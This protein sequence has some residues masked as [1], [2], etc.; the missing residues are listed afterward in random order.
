MTDREQGKRLIFLVTEL[1]YFCSHRLSLA[2]KAK[3]A[4]YTV[5][6]ITN[7]QQRASLARY[8]PSLAEL[9]ICHVPFN[10]SS[11]NPL[12]EVKV[13]GQILQLYRQIRPCI[14]HHVAIKGVLYGTL[15]ARLIKTPLII[16]ALGGLGHL[17]TNKSFKTLIIKRILI[18]GFRLVAN[19]KN[20]RWILQNP[21]DV[22]QM[23][24]YINYG[25]IHL[26]RG[27]GV[28]L[29]AFTPRKE[30]DYPPIIV[31][32]V[33]R[34]LWSKGLGE[35][36]EASKILK[37]Q[38]IA[39]E[40]QVAGEPDAHNPE[41]VPVETLNRWKKDKD[42]VWLG[43]REDIATL[44]GKSHMVILPSYREGLPRSLLEAL[45]CGKPVITT[46]APGCR[47]IVQSGVNGILIPPRNA[48]ALAQAMKQLAESADMRLKMGRASRLKAEQEFDEELI[49]AQTLNL[50]REEI[51]L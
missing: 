5:F 18:I 13:I 33:A 24:V 3:Q 42:V 39:V 47:E 34:L 51:V 40:I 48:T 27:A 43:Q 22:K 16:N 31:V 50:Y 2:L 30:P 14:V 7:C 8:E 15:C 25:T 11:L 12:R 29:K 21:D 17:F 20:C 49:I 10:R 46:D 28:N 1:G 19:H 9:N 26:V 4:G 44:Y 35:V 37:K 6:V 32:M 41:S 45:A 36:V 38:G 23:T